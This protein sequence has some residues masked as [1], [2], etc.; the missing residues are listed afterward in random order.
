MEAETKPVM[1][2]VAMPSVR[3]EPPPKG[4]SVIV[5]LIV[6]GAMAGGG[7]A[8]YLRTTKA[9]AKAASAPA[10]GGARRG[11]GVLPVV[12][13]KSRRGDMP[14]YLNGLGSVSA[15]NTVTVR[16]RVDGE[17]VRVV[18]KEGQLV[19]KGDLLAEID[20]RP[21]QVQLAQAEGQLAKDTATLQNAK[22]DLERNQ[23][24]YKALAISKQQLDTQAA[25]VAQLEGTLKA[26]QGPIENAKLQMAYSRITAPLTGRIGLRLV[27]QGNIVHANDANGLA[28]IA[29]LQPIA[30]LFNLPQDNLPEVARKLRAGQE[31]RVDAFDRDLKTR[32]ASG[33]LLTVD[34]AI[35]PATGTARFK[36]QFA[37][38]D[39]S[40]FPNQFVNARLLLDVERN[41]VLVASAAIQS[42]PQGSFVYV[43][44]QDNTVEMRP[45]VAGS[46]EGD[47]AI[48]KSGLKEGETVVIDGLDKLQQGSKVN[49]IPVGGRGAGKGRGA[50]GPGPGKAASGAGG[51][52]GGGKAQ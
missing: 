10:G 25:L 46:I 28:V 27:D 21:F 17:L 29:Q 39:S 48:V 45:I 34:N 40:L 9:P 1:T 50:G 49:P 41:Q 2:E 38:T 19:Q 4:Q 16:S 15:F 6:L 37:N 18:Y 13:S 7:Y 36:A 51:Q 23:L 8:I 31:L 26:D 20:T 42:S 3:R 24:L 52:R 22:V 33:R 44:K 32:L 5:W 11:G 43:V 12:V 14:V 35:D 47:D 30:V